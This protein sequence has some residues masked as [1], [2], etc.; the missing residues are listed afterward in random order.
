VDFWAVSP[1]G[2]IDIRTCWISNL[3]LHNV[4]ILSGFSH[5]RS[6]LA[7]SVRDVQSY[8]ERKEQ[9]PSNFKEE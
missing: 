3:P 9:Q 5:L 7:W 4:P 6:V 1:N 2:A 8:I